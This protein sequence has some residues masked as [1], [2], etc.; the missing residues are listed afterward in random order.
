MNLLVIR[1]AGCVRP[2]V[3]K[4]LFAC[5][6]GYRAFTAKSHYGR[7]PPPKIQG[8]DLYDFGFNVEQ[9]GYS[10][11]ELEATVLCRNS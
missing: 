3:V 5:S 11:S 4:N 10:I 6:N 2:S 1:E 8:V 7:G 9:Q